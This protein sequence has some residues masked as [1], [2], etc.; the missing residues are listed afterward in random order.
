V[1]NGVGLRTLAARTA[2]QLERF[3]AKVVRVS[4][5]RVYGKAQSE[6]HY[7]PGHLAGAR[8]VGQRLPVTA[9]MVEVARMQPGVNVR[10]VVGRD[11]VAGPMAWWSPNVTE[12]DSVTVA[13]K[14]RP[15]VGAIVAEAPA[16]PAAP[17]PEAAVPLSL[18]VP[19]PVETT[20]LSLAD[21]PGVDLR[22]LSPQ[23]ARLDVEDGWRHL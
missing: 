18:A 19:G 7:L 6:I 21:V 2:R 16:T 4:D 9:R 8:T 13:V 1:S 11:M 12:A 15:V 17:A 10:L 3:G 20:P 22:A 23:L 14:Q 5:F